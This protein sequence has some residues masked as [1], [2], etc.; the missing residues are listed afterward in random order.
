MERERHWE[1]VYTTKAPD[2]VSWY[3]PRL[4]RSLELIL[5]ARR[6]PAAVIDVGGGASTLVDDLLR[7]GYGPVTVLDVSDSALQLSRARLGSDSGRVCWLAGD[8]I[9]TDLPREA[10]DVW[11][12]R[13]AFHFLLD[14]ADRAAYAARAARSVRKGGRLVIATFAPD[15]PAKCSGL[16]VAR[17]DGAALASTLGPSFRLE[18]EAR[19]TH[20]T[21]WGAEQRF[22]YAV[23]ERVD[24]GPR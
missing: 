19:E 14:P 7:L 9:H 11:H 10:Y 15:G 21:P 18:A 8:V 22:T 23:L 3:A 1:E 24:P 13:A 12:D 17:Y 5:H 16:E 4:D 6:P 20:V 2:Q